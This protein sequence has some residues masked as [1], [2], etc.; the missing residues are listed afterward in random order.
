MKYILS[1]AVAVLLILGC[2]SKSLPDE[3]SHESTSNGNV[4]GTPVP[5]EPGTPSPSAQAQAIQDAARMDP[6]GIVPKNLL[7]KTVLYF[8][9]NQNTISNHSVI[10]VVDFSQHS[11]KA[12]FYIVQVNGSG[13]RAVHVAHGKNSDPRNT[14]YAT[15][16]GNVPGSEKSSLGFYLTAEKI[17]HNGVAHVL[18]GLST[19]DSNVRVR[20]IWLHAAAYIM[21]DNVQPGRSWGCLAVAYSVQDFVM[22]SFGVGGLIYVGQSAKE[23]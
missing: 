8:N 1:L 12:R 18:D 13:V 5:T 21:E 19:T 9:A 22:S 17:K 16:F 3:T 7:K 15:L 10:G 23:L 2:G 6:K 4:G 11:S 20:D 14:G